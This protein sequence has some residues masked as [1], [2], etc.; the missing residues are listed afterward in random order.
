L[1]NNISGSGGAKSTMGIRIFDLRRSQFR[2]TGKIGLSQSSIYNNLRQRTQSVYLQCL[3][4]FVKGWLRYLYS[5]FR[6]PQVFHFFCRHTIH[7]IV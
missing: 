2:K 6:K 1:A 3:S 5:A 4:S 7:I